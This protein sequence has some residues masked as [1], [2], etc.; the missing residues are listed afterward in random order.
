MVMVLP[1][2]AFAV[3]VF[4][5]ASKSTTCRSERRGSTD[6]RY[7]GVLPLGYCRR[8]IA[9]IR[10]Y[11]QGFRVG[12]GRITLSGMMAAPPPEDA[13][14]AMPPAATAPASTH[15]QT[16]PPASWEAPEVTS[17]SLLS[18]DLFKM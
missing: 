11:R 10:D 8:G 17:S 7:P 5:S 14:A 4:P 1:A 9:V 12:R 2:S 3:T 13:I 15:G 18:K 6:Y 16:A